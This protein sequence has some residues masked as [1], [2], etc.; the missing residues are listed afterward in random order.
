[1]QWPGRCRAFNWEVHA[2]AEL[3]AISALAQ[4]HHFLGGFDRSR[5]TFGS[6]IPKPM[7]RAPAYGAWARCWLGAGAMVGAPSPRP[8]IFAV[9]DAPEAVAHRH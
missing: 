3:S 4:T 7:C 8:S 1:M 6:R 9:H 2:A 5:Q